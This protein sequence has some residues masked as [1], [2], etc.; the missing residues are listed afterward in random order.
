M[1]RHESK[2][3]SVSNCRATRDAAAIWKAAL[4]AV[5]G[6]KLVCDFFSVSDDALEFGNHSVSVCDANRICLVAGGKAASA[7]SAGFLEKLEGSQFEKDGRLFGQ[8]NIPHQSRNDNRQ[9]KLLQKFGM[10]INEVRPAN[11]NLPTRA[12]VE[13]TQSIRGMVNS[14]EPTDLCVVLLSGGGSALLTEPREPVT[15]AE[16]LDAIEFMFANNADIVEVNRI[17]GAL[18]EV[19]QGGLIRDCPS[20]NIVTLLISDIIG[21]P[22]QLIAGGPTVFHMDSRAEVLE[23]ARRY[24]PG[25]NVFA[26]NIWKVLNG[27]EVPAQSGS[28]GE[29][30][31]NSN[32]RRIRHFVLANNETAVAAA[33][34]CAATLGYQVQ[35]ETVVGS[36]SAEEAGESLIDRLAALKGGQCIVSG[37]E[38]TVQLVSRDLRGSGGRNQQLVL[39]ALQQAMANELKHRRDWCLFSAGTD[40]QDGVSAAAGAWVDCDVIDRA[41]LEELDTGRSLKFNNAGEYFQRAG[42]LF[43]CGATHT[44]VCDLRIVIRT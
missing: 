20:Q 33:T 14:L 30:V 21:D 4:A 42:G 44:N 36:Q 37:G 39:A 35:S 23:I 26:R 5:H 22:I 16:K 43:E 18:S 12:A 19:K 28:R 41:S 15:L 8:L 32:P 24:D 17:R 25:E 1:N 9:K 38:P 2:M 7:M 31:T 27:N 40:G 13:A 3:E 6:R 29:H 10:K 34:S 11:I